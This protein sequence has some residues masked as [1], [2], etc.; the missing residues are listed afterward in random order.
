MSKIILNNIANKLVFA[1]LKNKII[2]PI[3][4]KYTKKLS[5][6]QK[7]RKLCESKINKPIAGFKAAGTSIPVLK[8]LKEKEPFYATVY[9]HNVLKNHLNVK[10]NKYT[11]GIELEVCY[12]IKKDF[13]NL[14]EKVNKNNFKKFISHIAPCIEVVGYRQRKK[15]IK[16][17][18]DLC[19][20]FG[21]NVKFIIGAKKKYKNN[22]VKNLVTKISNSKINQFVE[23]NT[24]TVYINPMNSLYFVLNKL[25][26]DKI[27]HNDD[28]YVFTGSTV[29]VVPILGKGIYKGVINKLGTVIAKIN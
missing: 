16:S 6:A 19:S 17:L 28:F 7:L 2:T 22:N 29:G 10:I 4:I 27:N 24:N 14:K 3:P 23:G 13:F 9:E 26:K 12:L 11:M 1:F 21:A 5:E 18:G 20:D 15:G 8:K 25:Q